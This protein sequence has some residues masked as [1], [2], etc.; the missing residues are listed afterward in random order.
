VITATRPASDCSP[1]MTDA[2]RADDDK[3]QAAIQ[4]ARG[5]LSVAPAGG[6]W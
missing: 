1:A 4:S 3:W 6:G 5:S 2:S